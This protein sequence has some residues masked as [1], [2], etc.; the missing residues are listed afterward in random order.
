M[1]SYEWTFPEYT[2]YLPIGA[3]V[4]TFGDFGNDFLDGGSETAYALNTI[5][6]DFSEDGD[7]LL[8]RP[9]GVEL[10]V[11]FQSAPSMLT[12]T[13]ELVSDYGFNV[14]VRDGEEVNKE[15]LCSFD[16][17]RIIVLHTHG[18]CN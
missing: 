17:Y 5:S 9:F 7:I 11:D 1:E 2:I 8:A 3:F 13:A 18:G 10:D 14:T 12:T 16:R 6:N 15:L 4:Y